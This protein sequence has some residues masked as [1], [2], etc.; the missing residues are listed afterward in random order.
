MQAARCHKLA[1]VQAM[2]L[3]TWPI[4]N[5]SH[6]PAAYSRKLSLCPTGPV[7][8]RSQRPQECSRSGSG[9]CLGVHTA[10]RRL[11]S[12]GSLDMMRTFLA[13]LLIVAGASCAAVTALTL[14][15]Q[16]IGGVSQ[17]SRWATVITPDPSYKPLLCVS[18]PGR[19]A[20]CMLRVLFCVI[21]FAVRSAV[22]LGHAAEYCAA[23]H[24]T[25]CHRPANP[26]VYLRHA[27]GRPCLRTRSP[28][29]TCL[30]TGIGAPGHPQPAQNT[31]LLRLH[32][33][34]QPNS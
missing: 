14:D 12:K 8:R 27:G 18:A 20:S 7:S 1:A 17:P 2:L 5:S 3:L 4:S 6:V 15:D 9:C 34:K 33:H 30:H 16:P 31:A 23:P 21:A 32:P 22:S 25:Y 24:L 19:S 28:R 29:S 26:G 11:D 10:V 13:A